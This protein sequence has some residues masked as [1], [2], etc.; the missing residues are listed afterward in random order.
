MIT[1][2][3]FH[4]LIIQDYRE[5][6]FPIPQH[7]QNYEELV[8][9]MKGSGTHVL[10]Q[11]SMGYEAGDILL[12]SKE[13]I[14]L[15]QPSE[16]TRIIAIKFTDAYF[17]TSSLPQQIMNHPLMKEKKPCFTLLEKRIIRQSIELI[18]NYAEKSDPSVSLF[19][20]YQLLAIF[21]LIRESMGR[22]EL[23]AHQSGPSAEKLTAYIQ[24]NIYYPD[25]LRI[26]CIAKEFSIAPGYFSDY[27]KRRFDMTFRSYINAYRIELIE[28]R[29]ETGNETLK[30][31]AA[32]LGF[33]DQSHLSHFYKKH[34]LVQ[35]SA[36]LKS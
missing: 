32:E 22:W 25:R 24:K 4:S 27:F 36:R 16:G 26:H 1:F 20:Q 30:Q 35:P 3:Q 21:G 23:P 17:H 14:H 8:F 12:I 34:K 9:V 5:E 18:L 31:I 13:D 19:V 28:Q 11:V 2:K 33:S 10:N 6:D 29:L 15:F 7:S